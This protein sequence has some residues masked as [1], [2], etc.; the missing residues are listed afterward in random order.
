M[1]STISDCLV[2]II[3]ETKNTLNSLIF[4]FNGY[5]LFLIH[6]KR[7]KRVV[8]LYKL[9]KQIALYVFKRHLSCLKHVLQIPNTNY[10]V[11]VPNVF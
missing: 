6:K 5:E 2:V 8:L 11:Y 3:K 4:Y 1:L 9:L 7:R 10:L